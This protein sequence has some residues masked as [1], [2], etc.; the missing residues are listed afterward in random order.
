MRQVT[1]QPGQVSLAAIMAKAVVAVDVLPQQRDLAH[2][3]L[4]QLHCLCQHVIERATK[5]FT[6]G[7]GHYAI[8]AV[9]AASLH[10]RQESFHSFDAGCRQAIEFLDLRETDVDRF[11][12]LMTFA[13]LTPS[14]VDHLRQTVQGLGSEDHINVGC[15]LDN[16][17]TFLAGD[18]TADTNNN[19]GI[20]ALQFV[21]TPE[22]GKHFFL[23]LLPDRAGI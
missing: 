18:T 10:D 1:D 11:R 3:L 8:T 9:L 4:C 20:I 12:L 14:L 2:T 7:I 15:P 13:L 6:S 22:L 23:R 5:L 16:R 21:P 19:V 17:L